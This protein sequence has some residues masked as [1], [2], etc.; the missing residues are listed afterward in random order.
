MPV[1]SS[2]PPFASQE[3][4]AEDRESTSFIHQRSSYVVVRRGRRLRSRRARGAGATEPRETRRRARGVAIVGLA[5]LRSNVP[6]FLVRQPHVHPHQHGK[7]RQRQQRRPLHEEA[8][9]LEV[10]PTVQSGGLRSCIC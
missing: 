5:E 4:A 10:A 7:H 3:T 2:Y 6:F 1:C 8:S 9:F